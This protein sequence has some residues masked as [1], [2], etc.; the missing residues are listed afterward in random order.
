MRSPKDSVATDARAFFLTRSPAEGAPELE[1]EDAAHA[2]RV[3]RLTVGDSVIGLDGEGGRWPLRVTRSSGGSFEV[4]AAGDVR[5]EPAPGT[6]GSPLP[7]IEVATCLPREKRAE[8]MLD[9]LVQLGA[10]A[11]CPLWCTRSQGALRELTESRLRR[12]QRVAREACKQC[13]RA[14]LPSFGPTLPPTELL[15]ARP[16]SPAA[17][18]DPDA[19]L[20]LLDWARDLPA[21]AGRGGPPVVLLVGPEGGFTGLERQDLVRL[22]AT[23]VRLGPHVLRIETAAEA[24]LAGLALALG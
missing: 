3:L 1:P 17:L 22:G 20:S 6:P 23:P 2:R 12:L 9:R 19:K 10:A 8:A 14:W 4:A 18:L 5:R 16:G 24:G 21:G 11:V 13:E 15:E 7:R